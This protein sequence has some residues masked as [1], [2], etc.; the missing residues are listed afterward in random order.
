MRTIVACSAEGAVEH[1]PLHRVGVL[2]LVD[3]HDAPPL[4]HPFTRRRRA[5]GTGL[6]GVGQPDQQVV[7]RQDPE[8]PLA[9]GDLV[10]DQA[11][12]VAALGR[13]RAGIGVGRRQRRLGVAH[14]GPGELE[15]HRP[16]ERRGAGR[17]AEALQVDVVDD[18]DDQ[19]VE[20][21]HQLGAR[22]GVARDAE[23]SA[24]PSGRTGGWWRWWRRRSRP[25]RRARGDGAGP[26]RRRARRRAARAG[27]RD[28]GPRPGRPGRGRRRRAARG[29]ARAAPGWPPARR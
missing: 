4:A 15:G 3:E 29:P 25:V 21:V 13:G 27:P 2:E 5:V 11:G 22:V 23:A 28:R 9:A 10:S 17:V 19:L 24:G 26:P 18:L 8:A 16:V 12:E 14:G 6:E 7:V 20:V 1:G